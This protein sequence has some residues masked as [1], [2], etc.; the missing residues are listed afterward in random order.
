V[1][2]LVFFLM[3]EEQAIYSLLIDLCLC[4]YLSENPDESIRLKCL[5]SL[6]MFKQP[7]ILS[8]LNTIARS[9][10]PS[11]IVKAFYYGVH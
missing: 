4:A 6:R 2:A 11:Y 8:I 7:K 5:E 3:S 9:S 10:S 1:Q